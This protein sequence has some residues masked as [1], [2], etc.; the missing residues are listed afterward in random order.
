MKNNT[1]EKIGN[2][3]SVYI[4]YVYSGVI[5]V[6]RDRTDLL[7]RI[8]PVLRLFEVQSFQRWPQYIFQL[9]SETRV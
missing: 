8:N 5:R 1:E 4:R 6:F 3:T 9:N 2:Y 7:L